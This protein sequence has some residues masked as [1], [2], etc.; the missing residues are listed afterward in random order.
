MRLRLPR[1]RNAYHRKCQTIKRSEEL[2]I[3]GLGDVSEPY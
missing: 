1:K 3:E 2:V